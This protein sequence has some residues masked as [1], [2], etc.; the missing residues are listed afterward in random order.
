MKTQKQ[1]MGN[2][3]LMFQKHTTATSVTQ[4]IGPYRSRTDEKDSNDAS[5]QESHNRY[6]PDKNPGA[7]TRE[8]QNVCTRMIKIVRIESHYPPQTQIVTQA[9]TVPAKEKTLKIH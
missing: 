9:W 1:F 3:Q 6:I 4:P 2:M 7:Y 8:K 5:Q